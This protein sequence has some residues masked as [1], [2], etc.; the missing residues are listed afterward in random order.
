MINMNVKISLQDS[1]NF[2]P[3]G[4]V[5]YTLKYLHEY[6]TKNQCHPRVPLMG[7]GEAMYLMQ[8]FNTQK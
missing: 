3:L 7:P 6:L 1:F 8:K 4:C 5:S 2:N